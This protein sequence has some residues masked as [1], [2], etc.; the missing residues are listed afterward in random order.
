MSSEDFS[1]VWHFTGPLAV[2]EKINY[3]FYNYFAYEVI[4][5]HPKSNVNMIFFM[6]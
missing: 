2:V 1:A 3:V 5:N 6:N 4:E